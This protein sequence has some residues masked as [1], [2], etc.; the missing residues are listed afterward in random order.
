MTE[1]LRGVLDADE[2]VL[3]DPEPLI[4]FNAFGDSSLNFNIYAWI[5]DFDIGFSTTHRLNTAINAALA[6]AGI[7]IP[8]PQRDVHLIPTPESS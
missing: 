6:D 8:F 4:V 5:A 3:D 1:V 7:T 2:E